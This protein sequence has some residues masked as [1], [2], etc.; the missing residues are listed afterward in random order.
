MTQYGYQ[1]PPASW[2]PVPPP[3]LPAPLPKKKRARWPWIIGGSVVAIIVVAGV[4]GKQSDTTPTA[5]AK[6]I[7]PASAAPQQVKTEA[8]APTTTTP[9]APPV[10][11]TGKG[12]DV[13]TID[14]PGVKIVK[15][16]CPR[17]GGNTVL[18][19]DGA[20]SLLVNT[21]GKYSGKHWVDVHDGSVTSTYTIKATG[22][23]TL[24]VGGIDQARVVADGPITGSGDDVVIAQHA[25]KAAAITNKG[26]GNFV[27]EVVSVKRGTIDLAVNEIGGY[28]GTV[29]F[30][31]PAI[32]QVISEGSWT[33]TPRS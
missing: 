7:A 13:I 30:N 33:I 1:P 26:K 12:D 17:C 15:F 9:P 21:I 25:A 29:A 2:A 19:T 32:V 16:D 22:A 24:S 3:P 20:E 18:E 4:T 31:G 11:K 6:A 8:P 27:V 5:P 14:R 10:V 28:S 23:W